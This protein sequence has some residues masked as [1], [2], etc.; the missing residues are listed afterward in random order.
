MKGL[1]KAS[2]H[3]FNICRLIRNQRLMKNQKPKKILKGKSGLNQVV[4]R[5]KEGGI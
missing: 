3:S 4:I 1:R 5:F 2:S